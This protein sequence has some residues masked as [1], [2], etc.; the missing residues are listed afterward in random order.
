MRTSFFYFLKDS[1]KV[2]GNKFA[3]TFRGN[4]LP[5]SSRWLH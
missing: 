5:P 2:Q 4:T 1:Y 3:P